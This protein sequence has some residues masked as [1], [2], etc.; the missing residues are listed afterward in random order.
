MDTSTI[1][2]VDRASRKNLM[3]DRDYT[4]GNTRLQPNNATKL[5]SGEDDPVLNVTENV[6]VHKEATKEKSKSDIH[7]TKK[8]KKKKK[9][10]KKLKP[11]LAPDFRRWVSLPDKDEDEV[12]QS[13]SPSI[14]LTG[15]I[16]YTF[17]CCIKILKEVDQPREIGTIPTYN[18]NRAQDA[19]GCVM[20][21]WVFCCPGFSFYRLFKCCAK[22]C[23][24]CKKSNQFCDDDENCAKYCARIKNQF[25][26]DDENENE[27]IPVTSSSG[28]FDRCCC[29][30]YCSKFIPCCQRYPSASNF[31][32]GRDRC[33][34]LTYV[35]LA[36]QFITLIVTYCWGDV[37]HPCQ[38]T[39]VVDPS[40]SVIAVMNQDAPLVRNF[41]ITALGTMSESYKPLAP[42][43]LEHSTDGNTTW[44]N[45]STLVYADEIMPAFRSDNT[46]DL[47]FRS[48]P[49]P[50]YLFT[51]P[52]PNSLKSFSLAISVVTIYWSI[53]GANSFSNRWCGWG[54]ICWIVS[55]YTVFGYLMEQGNDLKYCAQK[56]QNDIGEE[57]DVQ[58]D[59]PTN[60][61]V[62]VYQNGTCNNWFQAKYNHESGLSGFKLFDDF[63]HAGNFLPD[64]GVNQPFKGCFT[65]RKTI[66]VPTSTKNFKVLDYAKFTSTK[67]T[68]N[69]LEQTFEE[70]DTI[71]TCINST[72]APLISDVAIN[73]AL[74]ASAPL[75]QE[76]QK[77]MQESGSGGGSGAFALDQVQKELISD[78]LDVNMVNSLVPLNSIDSNSVTKDLASKVQQDAKETAAKCVRDEMAPCLLLG[79]TPSQCA[80]KCAQD[81]IIKK[82]TTNGGPTDQQALLDCASKKLTT[83]VFEQ[84]K[85]QLS[86]CAQAQT[87]PSQTG[88]DATKKLQQ[89]Q[90]ETVYCLANR[91]SKLTQELC[92]SKF[93]DD[94]QGLENTI[95]NSLVSFLKQTLSS[96][97]SLS[98]ASKDLQ[99]IVS[100]VEMKNSFKINKNTTKLQQQQ[101][102]NSL[103]QFYPMIPLQDAV[104]NHKRRCE[105]Y[106]AGNATTFAYSQANVVIRSITLF[107]F[108]LATFL[109]L[110][111]IA[112][113]GIYMTLT[114]SKGLRSR[115]CTTL[116]Q[117][118]IYN[119]NYFFVFDQ[120]M[121]NCTR[122]LYFLR[123]RSI[124][125]SN[126][127]DEEDENGNKRERSDTILMEDLER[128]D[129]EDGGTMKD[130]KNNN[131]KGGGKRCCRAMPPTFIATILATSVMVFWCFT[132]LLELSF[133][134]QRYG[135]MFA[136]AVLSIP[137]TV[138]VLEHRI[139]KGN[140][141]S[142]QDVY[143]YY[144]TPIEDSNQIPIQ[145]K[146]ILDQ[147]VQWFIDSGISEQSNNAIN[148][149]DPIWI[150]V[151]EVTYWITVYTI[152]A[153]FFASCIAF[154]SFFFRTRNLWQRIAAVSRAQKR[155]IRSVSL[156]VV[157][158][159]RSLHLSNTSTISVFTYCSVFSF[160]PFGSLPC[161]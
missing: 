6:A 82:V 46:A 23:A 67:N 51:Y 35:L 130:N 28:C 69:T 59:L 111:F 157:V 153:T 80:A 72:I 50:S 58:N 122:C 121:K 156:F 91:L 154:I 44:M 8:K 21:C 20:C 150:Y 32:F 13:S 53:S 17:A 12:E 77:C 2:K 120:S 88:G 40:K 140:I 148:G 74:K 63:L 102:E 3:K 103:D 73:C 45:H 136:N 30:T 49:I 55:I 100:T 29:A 42:E 155:L 131:I 34:T 94:D 132:K 129:D 127:D 83:T 1:I 160:F 114:Q 144:G 15:R 81:A 105:H 64:I 126:D 37:T 124:K 161:F 92:L 147:V 9:H 137:T 27:T 41:K 48:L 108:S 95:S 149:T 14:S 123:I 106:V 61:S 4:Q 78:C 133:A 141:T 19:S 5:K 75:V 93:G 56:C 47:W 66:Q 134:W 25:C 43:A 18:P 113:D 22:C 99:G 151:F 139:E 71:A 96:S 11:A 24:T 84:G 116:S 89:A 135:M 138:Q 109:L 87:S 52:E 143:S 142:S 38:S 110:I 16:Y 145:A 68:I 7:A 10:K 98:T 101:Q 54:S 118:K 112:I 128:D 159:Y 107:L 85:V 33:P 104:K 115:L 70:I 76:F 146:Q 57:F 26:D 62:A 79:T 97:T 90:K 152:V 39:F 60:I 117:L 31:H 119:I 36:W 65:W 125:P 158:N 86:K